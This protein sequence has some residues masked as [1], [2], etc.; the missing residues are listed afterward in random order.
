M[1][2]DGGAVKSLNYENLIFLCN[3]KESDLLRQTI[4]K[5]ISS[6]KTPDSCGIT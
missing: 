1:S 5:I 3:I 6:G 2:K 4:K